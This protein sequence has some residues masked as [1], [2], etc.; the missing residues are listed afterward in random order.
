MRF[1]IWDAYGELPEDY[2]GVFDVVHLRTLYST[3]VG[4]KVDPLLSNCLKM[5]KPGGFLQWDESDASTLACF[6]PND[7]VKSDATRS[8]VRIQDATA[9]TYSKMTPDWLHNLP[10][11]LR[12]RGCEIL[13]LEEYA[14]QER[15]ARGWTDNMLL[16]WQSLV[17]LIPEG[18]EMPLPP[19]DDLPKTL[20]KAG[21]TKLFKE[22]LVETRNGVMVGMNY[23]VFLAKKA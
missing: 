7:S 3:V 15:L 23:H 19:G 8:L 21:Y 9:R 10:D 1:E 22:A 12:E 6:P 16:V 2:V 4:N 14:P 13:A 18:V 20:S 17:G 11:T 5:L